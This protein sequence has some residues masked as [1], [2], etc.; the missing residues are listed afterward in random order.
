MI[1]VVRAA[2]SFACMRIRDTQLTEVASSMTLTTLLSLVPLLAVSL[3]VFAAFPS[4]ADS[5]QALET[6]VFESFLPEQYRETIVAAIREFSNHASGLGAFGLGG[7]ALTALL[8]IDKFFVTVNCIFKVRSMRPWSQRAVLY[9]AILTL[10]PFLIGISLTLST[11]AIRLAAGHAEGLLPGWMIVVFQ[12]LLQGVGYAVLYKLVPNCWVPFGHALIGGMTVAVAGQVVKE[13]FEFYVTSGTLTSIYGAFVAFPVFLLWLYVT[14]LLVFAGAAVTATIPLLTSGRYRDS[15]RPGNDFLTGVALLRV[16]TGAKAA[17]LASVPV[18]VLADKVDSYPEA[19]NRIL[20]RLA[21]AGYCGELKT[22]R[23]VRGEWAL[24]CDP[25]VKTLREALYALLID[26]DNT[27][28]QPDRAA[29]RREEG[30]L[31]G[32]WRTFVF[33]SVIDRPLSDFLSDQ[34]NEEKRAEV[35]A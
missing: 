23:H 15:Y 27:L 10:A 12:L 20:G 18:S 13:G 8:L 1:E 21:D 34:Q 3:A 17:G 19:V 16:L 6:M 30:M 24:L 5:R 26:P 9:W 29:Q 2:L 11:Q 4:F 25:S 35:K 33:D 31:F 28:V 14:W 7:L 32:W 22:D